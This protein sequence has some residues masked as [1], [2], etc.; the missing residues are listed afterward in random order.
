MFNPVISIA[1]S[2][3][4]NKKREVAREVEKYFEA[5]VKPDTIRKRA[6]RI[7]TGT[8]VPPDPTRENY[9]E[10]KKNQTNL[11]K[12]NIGSKEREI[13]Y[14]DERRDIHKGEMPRVWPEF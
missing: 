5:K 2:I 9:E 14:G 3:P 7:Q 11:E 1:L 12:S 4:W 8:N 6:S 13:S 10:T